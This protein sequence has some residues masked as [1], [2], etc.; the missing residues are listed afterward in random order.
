LEKKK[1]MAAESYHPNSAVDSSDVADKNFVLWYII[2]AILI[3]FFLVVM[4][5][6]TSAEKDK[7]SRLSSLDR[8]QKR[9]S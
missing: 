9:D 3:F 2:S 5:I 7:I 8:K 6:A 4:W 1:L